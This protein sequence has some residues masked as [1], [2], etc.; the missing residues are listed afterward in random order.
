MIA[1]ESKPFEEILENLADSQTVFIVGCGDCATLCQTGGEFEVEQMTKQLEEAGKQ[2][3]GSVIPEATCN[4]LDTARL[5]RQNKEAVAEA[6]TILVLACGS[7]VQATAEKT[8]KRVIPGC[9]TI[10][11]S[12]QE[13]LGQMSERCICCGDCVVDKYF[14]ICPRARCPKGQMY[15]PCGGYDDGKCEV[16]PEQDCVWALIYERAEKLGVGPEYFEQLELEADDFE[17]QKHPRRLLFEP[18][19]A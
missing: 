15:G 16:D 8:S 1:T 14:G 17:K 3:T 9:N 19:R 7:G 5:L 10:F 6:D 2:V 12:T 4:V 11:L 18:R 13:R